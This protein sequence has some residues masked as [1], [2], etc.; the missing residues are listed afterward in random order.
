VQIHRQGIH[1]DD[2]GILGA[3]QHGQRGA[4]PLVIADPRALRRVMPEHR[5]TL[6]VD[7]F[8]RDVFRGRFG[9]QSQRMTAQVH[10]AAA[11]FV[12][13][14]MKFGGESRQRIVRIVL[15]RAGRV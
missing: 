12:M 2:F 4:R 13:R 1:G 9:L 11:G 6:P 14:M 3:D 7:Q 5:Q 10:Q 15:V 8:L